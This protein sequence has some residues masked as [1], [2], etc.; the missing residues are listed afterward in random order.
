MYKQTKIY[1][2]VEFK[3]TKKMWPLIAQNKTDFIKVVNQ[4]KLK[5]GN[6]VKVIR[7]SIRL[8]DSTAI[9]GHSG[10]PQL[11]IIKGDKK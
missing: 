3:D 10:K 8:S 1:F 5:H 2:N 11:Y 6:N 9:M 4:L 7:E